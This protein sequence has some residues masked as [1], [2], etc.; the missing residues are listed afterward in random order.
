MLLSTLTLS[1]FQRIPL[2]ARGSESGEFVT[3]Q[4]RVMAL[5]MECQLGERQSD[6]WGEALQRLKRK[7]EGCCVCF[8]LPRLLEFTN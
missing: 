5:L 1:I 4:A 6:T 2:C 7:V 8:L 3:G